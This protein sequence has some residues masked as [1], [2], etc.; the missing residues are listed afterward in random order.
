MNPLQERLIINVSPAGVVLPM[1]NF[2]PSA[3]GK[4]SYFVRKNIPTVLTLEN[5]RQVCLL[6]LLIK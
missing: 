5:M 1:N 4:S 6:F 2:A 3:K